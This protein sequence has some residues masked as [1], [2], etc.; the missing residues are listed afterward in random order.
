MVR[1]TS[2]TGAARPFKARY[3]LV[4]AGN[5]RVPEVGSGELFES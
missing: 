5:D 2:E 1:L 4:D 3:P